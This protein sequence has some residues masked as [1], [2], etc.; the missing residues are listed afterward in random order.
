VGKSAEEHGPVDNFGAFVKSKLAEGLRGRDLADA[1]AIEH[2]VRGKGKP[3]G[4][5]DRPG[6]GGKSHDN[7]PSGRMGGPDGQ[8]D[9]PGK[10]PH[11]G[12]GKQDRAGGGDAKGDGPGV[13]GGKAEG[14]AKGN[15]GKAKGDAKGNGGGKGKGGGR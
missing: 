4:I 15:G 12:E 7:G 3:K 13:G 10:P 14:D 2:K 8:G 1:I 9:G 6:S 5:E 11:A